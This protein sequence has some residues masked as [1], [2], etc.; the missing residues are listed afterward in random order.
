[1][2]IGVIASHGVLTSG[3]GYSAAVLADSPSA[4]ARLGE[5]SGTTMVDSS[6]NARHGTYIGSPMPT[7]G[8]TGLLTGDSDKALGLTANASASY[9]GFWADAAWM[10]VTALT[11]ECLVNLSSAVD[12]SAGDAIVT[13]CGAGGN[14]QWLLWR[15]GS[16]NLACRVY[17][18]SGTAHNLISPTTMA[19]NTT[20][21]VAFTLGGTALKLYI[22]GTQVGSTVTFSGSIGA[23]TQPIQIGQYNGLA[24]T[25]P[26]GVIDEVAIYDHEVSGTRIAAHAAAA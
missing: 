15:P 9:G 11:V 24:T 23:I 8:V 25:V 6:G 21:H 17:N 4:Y 2:S 16:A 5:T 13:R 3:S 19:L 26:G 7:L 14:S 22:N 20:Y 12:T 18:T 1:V 10:D